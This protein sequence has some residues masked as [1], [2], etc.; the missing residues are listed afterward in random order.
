MAAGSGVDG[1]VAFNR[2]FVMR[3][4]RAEMNPSQDRD[5]ILYREGPMDPEVGVVCFRSESSQTLAMLLHHTCHPCH[6]FGYNVI[7]AGWPGAWANETKKACGERCVPLVINGC[8][9]NVI[10]RDT[11]DPT[12]VDDPDHMGRVLAETTQNVLGKI[13]YQHEAELDWT[14]KHIKI[15]LRELDPAKVEAARKLLRERPKPVWLDAAHMR[16][17]REWFYALSTVDLA[18]LREREPEFDYEIQVFRVGDLAIVAL[19]GEPFVQAQLRIK[20]E[21][22]ARRTY[23]AHMSNGYVGYLP[24]L[25]ALQRGGYETRTAF[26]SKLAP[27]AL[28]MV[29]EETIEAIQGLFAETSP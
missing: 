28:D 11:L 25:E 18:G 21:S 17:D 7:T 1:R 2:R 16:V 4:G 6:A 24:T 20:L 10:H 22:P 9:G 19:V 29:T 14:T 5:N 13:Q 15:P 23:I 27:D 3:D 12:Q 8:C 26:W